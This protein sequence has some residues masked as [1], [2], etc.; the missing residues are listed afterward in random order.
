MWSH[1]M[2]TELQKSFAHGPRPHS[3]SFEV[4]SPLLKAGLWT[5]TQHFDL[6]LPVK[7]ISLFL[8]A[9]LFDYKYFALPAS[10]KV[11]FSVTP[12]RLV[13][14]VLYLVLVKASLSGK[15]VRNSDTISE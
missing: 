10:V 13:F 6:L 9:E 2:Q 12:D 14:L 1:R 8:F 7:L 11:L 5:V 15:R 4:E 3:R